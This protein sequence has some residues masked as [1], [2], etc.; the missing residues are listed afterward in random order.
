VALGRVYHL[1]GRKRGVTVRGGVFNWPV[2]I[3]AAIV[4]FLLLL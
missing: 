4:T 1:T 3:L 2:V